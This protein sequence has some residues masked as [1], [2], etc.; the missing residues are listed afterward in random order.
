MSSICRVGSIGLDWSTHHNYFSNKDKSGSTIYDVQDV[1]GKVEWKAMAFVTEPL[2]PNPCFILDSNFRPENYYLVVR[3][4]SAETRRQFSV[5]ECFDPAANS[6]LTVDINTEFELP[7]DSRGKATIKMKTLGLT[8]KG[9]P[10][11]DGSLV[12]LRAGLQLIFFVV[13]HGNSNARQKIDG[14]KYG[15]LGADIFLLKRLPCMF[16]MSDI[17]EMDETNS[18]QNNYQL[19]SSNL[20]SCLSLNQLHKLPTPTLVHLLHPSN[21]H[22]SCP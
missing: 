17:S 6:W 16:Q 21:L 4:Q 9:F 15:V 1:H 14:R 2:K 22:L 18:P 7:F 3:V 11:G 12:R 20:L 8:K 19:H 13:P 10:L 5:L